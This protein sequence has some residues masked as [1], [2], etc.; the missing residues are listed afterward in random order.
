MYI[1]EQFDTG[2]FLPVDRE[3]RAECLSWLFWQMGSAP[4]LGGGFGHFYNYAPIKIEYA[5]DRFAMEAKRQLDVL[6]R[7]LGGLDD[8][9]G[10]P[11]LCGEQYTIADMAVYAWYG[12]LVQG[13]IY[14]AGE[15]LDVKSY[16]HVVAWAERIKARPATV[17]GSKVNRF[18]GP[19]EN[20]LKE[21]HSR[22]DF[23]AS[24]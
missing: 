12:I 7:R 13:D 9:K 17:R 20:Q 3:L 24:L 15:F 19:P 1:C 2:T 11:Y 22:A 16:T 18:W 14:N 4:Y 10:G 6:N 21:R 23:D 5:I 8:R